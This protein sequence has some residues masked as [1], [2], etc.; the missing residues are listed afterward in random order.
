MY[1][2]YC[3]TQFRLVRGLILGHNC[4][5]RLTNY[6]NDNNIGLVKYSKGWLHGWHIW[7]DVVMTIKKI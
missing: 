3:A 5:E 7:P 2:A 6:W 4:E 1:C